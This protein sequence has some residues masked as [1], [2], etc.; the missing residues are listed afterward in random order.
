M[1]E[2]F[3]LLR[4]AVSSAADPASRAAAATYESANGQ[5]TVTSQVSGF[6]ASQGTRERPSGRFPSDPLRPSGSLVHG[7]PETIAGRQNH[8]RR[9]AWP[10]YPELSYKQSRAVPAHQPGPHGDIY[11]A[12]KESSQAA[13]LLR[14]SLL[15]HQAS[16]HMT[17]LALPE[18]ISLHYVR[19]KQPKKKPAVPGCS[20]WAS[21]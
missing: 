10:V 11:V 20:N 2:Y 9:A 6:P 8:F 19:M 3:T 5:L 16:T 12:R 7:M 4:V 14:F 1:F 13:D 15:H 18:D 17:I 21:L